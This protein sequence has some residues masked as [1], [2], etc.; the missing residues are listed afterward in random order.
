MDKPWYGRVRMQVRAAACWPL[1]H[2]HMP[3][4]A[5]LQYIGFL[6]MFVLYMVIYT[7]WARIGQSKVR[8]ELRAPSCSCM[9]ACQSGL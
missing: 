8:S 1:R 3:C 4:A 9:V 2:V 7:Q 5:R 6:A